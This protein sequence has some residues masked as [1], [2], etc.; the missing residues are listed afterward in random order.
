MG[1]KKG[2]GGGGD[3]QISPSK[4]YGEIFNIFQKK[5]VPG[6]RK[7]AAQ[8]RLLKPLTPLA[9]QGITALPGFQQQLTG[10]FERYTPTAELTGPL[11]ETYEN[12]ITPILQ[13]QGRLTPQLEREETQQTAARHARS[14]MDTTTRGLYSDR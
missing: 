4:E 11:K 2:G 9:E 8:E 12:Y 3:S 10:A 1:N 14:G 5:V 6:Y 13:S 7:F